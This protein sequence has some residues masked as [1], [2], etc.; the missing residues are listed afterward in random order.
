MKEISKKL[1]TVGLCGF[2][3]VIVFLIIGNL[4]FPLLHNS[5]FELTRMVVFMLT[6]LCT[7]AL[8]VVDIVVLIVSFKMRSVSLNICYL[9]IIFVCA[10]VGPYIVYVLL[11]KEKNDIA[12]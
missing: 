1:F 11:A 3:I 12:I 9:L 4:D 10:L 5:V 7:I 8:I 2:F 6:M